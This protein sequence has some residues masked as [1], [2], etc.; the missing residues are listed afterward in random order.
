[1][2]VDHV[3]HCA[4]AVLAALRPCGDNAAYADLERLIG[5]LDEADHSDRTLDDL[6]A[7]TDNAA[8]GDLSIGAMPLSQWWAWL[9]RLREACREDLEGRQL[10]IVRKA[11]SD[12]I[13]VPVR[14][15]VTLIPA[16][17]HTDRRLPA[18]AL[19]LLSAGGV[20]GVAGTA[21]AAAIMT[22]MPIGRPADLMIS[23]VVVL[24]AILT[25]GLAL[26][27]RHTRHARQRPARIA[28][29]E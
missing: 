10:D 4:N 16:P 3:R 23:G 24:A 2:S 13:Q 28:P 11:A 17:V 25:G 22:A 19:A 8:F 15:P 27:A 29:A 9:R 7:W 26:R 12:T 20:L 1:M 14:R 18:S 21:V 6:I 5:D